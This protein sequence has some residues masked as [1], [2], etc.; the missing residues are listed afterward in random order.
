MDQSRMS[1]FVSKTNS[2][3][4]WKLFWDQPH[5]ICSRNWSLIIRHY[6]YSHIHDAVPVILRVHRTCCFKLVKW[7]AYSSFFSQLSSTF[8]PIWRQVWRPKRR[9]IVQYGDQYSEHYCPQYGGQSWTMLTNMTS[10]MASYKVANMAVASCKSMSFTL[11][12]EQKL[13]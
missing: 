9:L 6:L 10:P 12:A 3:R 2:V 1:D 13:Q 8:K 11:L 4:I 7:W 5:A